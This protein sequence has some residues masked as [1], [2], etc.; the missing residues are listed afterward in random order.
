MQKGWQRA[1]TLQRLGASV[2]RYS[3]HHY[4]PYALFRPE[5]WLLRLTRGRYLPRK[6]LEFNAVIA[7]E[8]LSQ[9]PDVIWIEK[10]WFLL[11]ATLQKLRSQL[12]R[13]VFVNYQTDNPF[14]LRKSEFWR[15]FI[16]TLP[17]YDVCF[18]MRD[19]DLIRF[20]R[21]GARQV[22]L[23]HYG[24]FEDIFHPYPLAEIPE[25]YRHEV[26]F[27][28]TALDHRTQTVAQLLEQGV[29]LHIYGNNW[30]RFP[31]HRQ[32][33][34]HFHGQ[35]NEEYAQIVSGSK[36][37]LGFV[38]SSNLDVYTDRSIEIPACQG[39]F[40]GE[41][42]PK[43][44]NLYREGQEAEFFESAHECLDKIRYYLEHAE[45]RE[46]IAAAG[47]HRCINSNY[48]MTRFMAECLDE[49]RKLQLW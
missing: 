17:Q 18:V 12:P 11:P 20:K 27:I 2:H 13:T 35:A 5:W 44:Q 46:K 25:H 7:Q 37:A 40:L 38:S 34:A 4:E 45:A 22:K 29:P 15:I 1:T 32:Y 42:T 14:G 36:I 39:F 6:V 43:H 9:K 30:A 3:P 21:H 49:I 19:E 41:R 8:I 47:Y 10:N 33:R 24:F 31:V 28:G 23:A 26:V 48:S 16:D